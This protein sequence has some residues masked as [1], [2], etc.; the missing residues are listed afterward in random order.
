MY[1]GASLPIAFSKV[2]SESIT[3]TDSEIKGLLKTLSEALNITDTLLRRAEYYRNFSEGITLT[4]IKVLKLI[5]VLLDNITITD[6]LTTFRIRHIRTRYITARKNMK[7]HEIEEM[8]QLLGEIRSK[9][10]GEMKR[11]FR[12]IRKRVE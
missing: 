6:T 3:I 5:K 7:P 10:L 12:K 9:D 11:D 2:L 4:D 8:K 1:N